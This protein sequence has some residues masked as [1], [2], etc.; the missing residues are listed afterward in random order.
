[1]EGGVQPTGD[2][3]F[4]IGWVAVIDRHGREN[5]ASATRFPLPDEIGLAVRA[6]RELGPLMDEITGRQDTNRAEGAIGILTQRVM[7]RQQSF[8][9]AVAYA[10]APWLNPELYP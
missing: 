7:T 2:H 10:L 8:E 4:L 1:L 6:G 9:A 5:I 3:V